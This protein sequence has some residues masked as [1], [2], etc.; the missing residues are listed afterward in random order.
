MKGRGETIKQVIGWLLILLGAVVLSGAVADSKVGG[1]LRAPNPDVLSASLAGVDRVS[2]RANTGYVRVTA[3]DR[4][5]LA[6][7]VHGSHS[8]WVDAQLVLQGSE[9]LVRVRAPWWHRPR[10]TEPIRVEVRLPEAFRES[11]ALDVGEGSLTVRGASPDRPATWQ[12]LDLKVRTGKAEVQHVRTG[13][14]TF[15][16]QTGA[17]LTE[18]VGAGEAE[19][20]LVTG[21]LSLAHFAGALRAH[22]TSGSLEAQ[23]A[24]LRGPV[25]VEQVQGR[26]LLDMPAGAGFILNAGVD[27]G[28]IRNELPL[29]SRS[30]SA[31]NRLSGTHGAGTHAVD[32][33]LGRGEIIVR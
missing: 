12:A 16:G 13:R 20:R 2:V 18:W 29:E 6:V 31:P 30:S 5:D 23:F 9:L 32:L 28:V 7:S 17:F 11:L 25:T 27:T 1:W 8:G 24:T 26:L 22:L 14:L 4:P 3:E 10:N 19:L 15:N 33:R 21:R